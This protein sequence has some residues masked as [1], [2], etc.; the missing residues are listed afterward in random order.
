MQC[1]CADAGSSVCAGAG[2][3]AG[4]CSG[5]LALEPVFVLAPEAALALA[6]ALE[7]ASALALAQVPCCRGLPMSGAAASER[8]HHGHEHP[9]F[10]SICVVG[11]E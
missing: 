3:G 8:K 1:L 9:T 2:T 7:L 4:A 5:R 10:T 11:G 6:L